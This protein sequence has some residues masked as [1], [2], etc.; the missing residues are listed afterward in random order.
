[1]LRQERCSPGR[2]TSSAGQSQRWCTIYSGAM[3]ELAMG[4]TLRPISCIRTEVALFLK[5]LH[6][7]YSLTVT[8]KQCQLSPYLHGSVQRPQ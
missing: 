2:G 6:S 5:L 3:Q 4:D 8:N 7:F 1:M